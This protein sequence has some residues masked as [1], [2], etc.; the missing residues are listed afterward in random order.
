MGLG[1]SCSRAAPF[2][3]AFSL[4]DL[5]PVR[6]SHG[7][8]FPLSTSFRSGLSASLDNFLTFKRAPV[9]PRP[10]YHAPSGHSSGL[11]WAP[12]RAH[13]RPWGRSIWLF[14]FIFPLSCS[15]GVCT[16][17]LDPDPTPVRPQSG[18][19]YPPPPLPSSACLPPAHTPLLLLPLPLRGDKNRSH[20]KGW[21]ED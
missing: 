3:E 17:S 14:W 9:Y 20:H 15:T 19:A 18:S 16:Y 4:N 5:K 8:S 10:L 11:Q 6:V 1:G 13:S 21:W 7:P 12:G 2:P